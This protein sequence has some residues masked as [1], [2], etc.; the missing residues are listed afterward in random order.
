M[1]ERRG[2]YRVLVEKHELKRPLERPMH[3]WEDNI[4]INLQELDCGYGLNWSG[5][6]RGQV[7]VGCECCNEPSGSIKCWVFLD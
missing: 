3:R 4:K 5:C 6:G 7:A 1:G 2:A